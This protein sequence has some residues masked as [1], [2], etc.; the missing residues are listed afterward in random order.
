MSKRGWM[1]PDW[2]RQH[3]DVRVDCPH[4]GATSLPTSHLPAPAFSERRA[5]ARGLPGSRTVASCT[6]GPWKSS[7]T[8]AQGYHA[9]EEKALGPESQRGG[10]DGPPGAWR[11]TVYKLPGPA[12]GPFVRT[13]LGGGQVAVTA[14]NG[15]SR[16]ATLCSGAQRPRPG[17]ALSPVVCGPPEAPPA[18]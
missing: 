3:T 4:G 9:P 7:R 17:Q 14:G 18:V 13:V 11:F 15:G 16:E 2:G 12:L 1:E 5:G 6:C 8:N 10:R